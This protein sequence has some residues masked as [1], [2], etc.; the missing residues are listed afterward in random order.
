MTTQEYEEIFCTYCDSQRCL[1]RVGLTIEE[2]C[3]YWELRTNDGGKEMIKGTSID[4]PT[5]AHPFNWTSCDACV[6]SENCKHKEGRQGCNFGVDD[7]LSDE[8]IHMQRTN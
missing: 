1:N 2:K 6:L 4:K 7:F 5:S 3:P 8:K